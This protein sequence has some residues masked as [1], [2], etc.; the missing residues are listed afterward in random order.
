MSLLLFFHCTSWMYQETIVPSSPNAPF[1][2]IYHFLI[3]W[4]KYKNA[5]RI[6]C[7]KY[8]DAQEL[9]H[10]SEGGHITFFFFFFPLKFS[11]TDFGFI[12]A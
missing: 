6:H 2:N 5:Q 12:H 1:A 8:K 9:T 11:S 4:A 3:R 10:V 7:V